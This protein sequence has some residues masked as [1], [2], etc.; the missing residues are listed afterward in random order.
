MLTHEMLVAALGERWP[1]ADVSAAAELLAESGGRFPAGTRALPADLVKAVQRERLLA[2]ML[3]AV[4]ELGYREVSVQDVIARAGVSRPTFYEHFENRED[5]FMTTLDVAA[6]RLRARLG[7]A[8]I[9][10][11]GGWR[12]R[13]RTGLEELL[14]FIA[15]EPD[16]ARTLILEARA[17]GPAARRRRDELLDR[18]AAWID[19]QV[20]DELPQPP[21]AVAAAGVVGGI[22]ALLCSR[23]KHGEVMELESAL[24]SLMYF[25]VLAYE[26]HEA[27]VGELGAAALR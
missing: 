6:E 26:G 13:L 3:R 23:L 18:A 14:G 15:A 11:G 19:A 27:A 2:G 20:R 21:L 22:E 8:A 5:C 16:A 24:P 17:A 7:V 4:A 10:A 1:A 25:A 9:E 12:G